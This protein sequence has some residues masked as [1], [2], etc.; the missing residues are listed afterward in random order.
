MVS[1]QKNTIYNSPTDG[2][3]FTPKSV[4]EIITDMER[5]AALAQ[6]LARKKQEILLS[7]KFYGGISGNIPFESMTWVALMDTVKAQVE[8]IILALYC[9][10]WSFAV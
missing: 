3:R 1:S 6:A 7:L 8:E 9:E 4:E 2:A 10:E 5:S